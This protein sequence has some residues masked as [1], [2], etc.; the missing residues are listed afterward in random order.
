MGIMEGEMEMRM[1]SAL[2]TEGLILYGPALFLSFYL[3]DM[4]SG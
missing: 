2:N 4:G 1:F 3:L